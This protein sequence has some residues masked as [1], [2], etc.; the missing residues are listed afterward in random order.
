MSV[1]MSVLAWSSMHVCQIDIVNIEYYIITLYYI[2]YS[3][4][5]FASRGHDHGSNSEVDEV[6]VQVSATRAASDSPVD[7]LTTPSPFSGSRDDQ[8]A[9]TAPQGRAAEEGSSEKK[10]FLRRRP[11]HMPVSQRCCCSFTKSF[12]CNCQ[13]CMQFPYWYESN[14]QFPKVQSSACSLACLACQCILLATCQFGVKC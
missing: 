2:C 3:N 1:L 9:H 14:N 13:C 5:L 12:T 11:R 8:G 7:E 6:H 10:P 4:I